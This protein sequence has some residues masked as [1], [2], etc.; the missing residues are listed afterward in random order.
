MW[1]IK[2]SLAL[3]QPAILHLIQESPPAWTQEAYRPPCSEYS[4]CCPTRVPPPPPGEGTRP[5]YPPGGGPDPGTPHPG[6]EGYQTWVPPRGGYRTW[7]PPRGGT[8][9]STPPRGVP[10]PG[11]PPTRPGY[12]PGGYLTRVPPQ[13]GGVPDPGTPPPQGGTWPGYPPGGVP[14]LGTPPGGY[15]TRVPPPGGVPGPPPRCGQTN[16]VKLLPSRRTTYAG[17]NKDVNNGF[18]YYRYICI[19]FPMFHKTRLTH[20]HAA[21]MITIAWLIGPCYNAVM[22]GPTSDAGEDGYCLYIRVGSV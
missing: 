4:F 22:V 14:D 13:E 5:G 16:K 17:G 3:L 6:G 12:P 9:P 11:T 19:V 8:W 20:S 10:D 1:C 18:Y 21:I 15:L 2:D 7:V